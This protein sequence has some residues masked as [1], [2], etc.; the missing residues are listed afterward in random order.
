MKKNIKNKN[1]DIYIKSQEMNLR[2][3]LYKKK[4]W[5]KEQFFTH[6]A[7]GEIKGK[8]LFNRP[9]REILF[10]LI[11]KEENRYLGIAEY[12]NKFPTMF[13]LD[14]DFEK[15]GSNLTSL[16][17]KDTYLN[18]VIP[19]LQKNLKEVIVDF[20][21]EM[22]DAVILTKNPYIK[23]EKK[24]KHG[25]H[26]VFP[27]LFI[28]K[29]DFNLFEEK[30]LKDLDGYDPT[31]TK[32]WLL[33]GQSKERGKGWY[34]ADIVLTHDGFVLPAKDYFSD[35]IVY[36]KEEKVIDFRGDVES[37]Y[38][39]IFSID[40][41]GRPTTRLKVKIE[42]KIIIKKKEERSKIELD[43]SDDKKKILYY[44]LV[45]LLSSDRATTRDT[46]RNVGYCIWGL[47]EEEGLDLFLDFSQK[48]S[49]YDEEGCKYFYESI[50]RSDIN[51][52]SLVH[53][54]RE[55]N[56]YEA[57]QLLTDMKE[58]KE[59]E[60]KEEGTPSGQ[61]KEEFKIIEYEKIYPNKT[62][63]KKNVGDYSKLLENTDI[64]CIKSNMG[65]F[66]TQ[67]LKKLFSQYRR[68][69][70]TTFRRSLASEFLEEFRE[71]GFKNYE[72][73][74]GKIKGDRIICQIDSFHKVRGEYDLIIHDEIVGTI[75]H[76]HS[77][78]KEKNLVWEAF[79]YYNKESNRVIILDALLN[80]NSIRL[81][82]EYK[83]KVF[84]LENTYKTLTHKKYKIISYSSNRDN[85]IWLDI[86]NFSKK[87]TVFIP[88]NSSTF[89]T[90]LK[91]FLEV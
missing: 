44:N 43:I 40:S 16:Y 68:I 53:W 79:N 61:E 28:N 64:L 26:I 84:V 46:W 62:I 63:C 19:Y 6:T 13:R 33:Y 58:E 20:R 3:I 17:E 5:S 41:Y 7:Q 78:V 18:K 25:L 49:E 76:I 75:G 69:L 48:S 54:A 24:I 10:K 89:A 77:F 42:K 86:L 27:N 15:E 66:K 1:L 70:I 32:P 57:N 55:D 9:S 11:L 14:F 8:F 37:Y 71:F 47:L 73:F 90:K 72:D 50:D 45:Y 74:K 81:M 60:E 65:T 59:E 88:T 22:L 52:G 87:G 51:L 30:Y 36:D 35:Y 31:F 82:R 91:L 12:P 80:K 67:N 21:K 23:N 29:E 56:Y 38:P 85:K 2:K 83:K 4:I 39:H 34:K